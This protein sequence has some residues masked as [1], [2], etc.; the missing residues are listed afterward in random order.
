MGA[1]GSVSDGSNRWS[2]GRLGESGLEFWQERE[3]ECARAPGELAEEAW[4][5][6]QLIEAI[7]AATFWIEARRSL[8]QPQIPF[9][10]SCCI[11]LCRVR[12]LNL[13]PFI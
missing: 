13:A 9:P 1:W 11:P 3:E 12:T 10:D 8:S 7:S 4:L 2:W 6:V 5:L